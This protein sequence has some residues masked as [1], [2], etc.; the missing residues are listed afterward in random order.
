M[1]ATSKIKDIISRYPLSLLITVVI[2]YV[3][4]C[5]SDNSGLYDIPYI[6]KI[7]HFCMY[8]GFCSVLWFEHL[9]SHKTIRLKKILYGA[10]IA[11]ITFSGIIEI[12]QNSFT[13]YRSGDWYD[14]LFNILGVI[15]AVFFSIYITKPIIKKYNL[16]CNNAE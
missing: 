11:P 12:A 13:E 10:I 4:L 16:Y 6:D 5:K 1:K 8:A 9:R 15:T 7:A 2:I 3:S 14:F